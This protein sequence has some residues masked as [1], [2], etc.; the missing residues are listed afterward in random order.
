MELCFF[1]IQKY[2]TICL[3]S[4]RSNFFLTQYFLL[5]FSGSSKPIMK[6][7]NPGFR[8]I[9]KFWRGIVPLKSDRLVETMVKIGILRRN[10]YCIWVEFSRFFGCKSSEMLFFMFLMIREHTQMHFRR[11]TSVLIPKSENRMFLKKTSFWG[12]L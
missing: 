11:V 10:P 6:R 1:V 8:S 5:K 2:I 12:S 9:W 7:S 4:N 3:S